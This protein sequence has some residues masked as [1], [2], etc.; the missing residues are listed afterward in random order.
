MEAERFQFPVFRWELQGA[1]MLG[2][3]LGAGDATAK[4]EGAPWVGQA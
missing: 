2:G 1:C 4:L 3:V